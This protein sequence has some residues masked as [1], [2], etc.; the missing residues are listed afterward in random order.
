MWTLL[1]AL[2]LIQI[3]L[4]SLILLYN[5]DDISMSS[6]RLKVNG[7]QWY[8]G[9]EYSD[10]WSKDFNSSI[11]FDTYIIPVDKLDIG[12]FRL[13]DIDFRP[14]LPYIVQTRVLISRIDVLHS[15][16]IP[17]LGVK[18]DANPGRL[19]QLKF[20]NYRPGIFYG[21]CSEICGANH[22]F[23]PISLEF[24]RPRDFLSWVIVNRHED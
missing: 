10:F 20:I 17:R 16:T 5:L 3:A 6:V 4:P 19:N 14:V 1:P 24:L 23:I 12:A 9:Y 13:L 7:H 15:W 2:V 8:W 22:R 18:V 11:E 21:Q